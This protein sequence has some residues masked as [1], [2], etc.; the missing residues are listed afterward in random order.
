[1]WWLYKDRSGEHVTLERGKSFTAIQIERGGAI[2]VRSEDTI[3]ALTK[4]VEALSSRLEQ[5][6]QLRKV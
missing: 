3:A 4:Q 5:K 1:M 6:A 2:K